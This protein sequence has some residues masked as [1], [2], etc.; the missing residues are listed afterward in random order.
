L[1]IIVK[2]VSRYDVRKYVL[3]KGIKELI[4]VQSSFKNNLHRF[5]S[6]QEVNNKY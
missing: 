1:E 6:N 2:N 3:P 5:W 4:Q